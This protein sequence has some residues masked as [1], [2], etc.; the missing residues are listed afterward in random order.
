[1]NWG[2]EWRHAPEA[3]AEDFGRFEKSQLVE[4]CLGGRRL[5]FAR[6]PRPCGRCCTWFWVDGKASIERWYLSP[7]VEKPFNSKVIKSFVP[8]LRS[9]KCFSCFGIP[10]FCVYMLWTFYVR[11]T[12][13][14]HGYVTR[15]VNLHE[16]V[17]VSVGAPFM[18]PCATSE[19]K[20]LYITNFRSTESALKQK[21]T[22]RLQ[23]AGTPENIEAVNVS[24]QQSPRRSLWKQGAAVNLSI[25]SLKRVH[26]QD[27]QIHSYKTILIQERGKRDLENRRILCAEIQ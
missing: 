1:M 2:C 15:L 27:L 18:R 20:A 4:F 13:P 10:M 6:S 7:Y 25:R 26:L 12:Y 3:C 19:Q 21:S 14:Y 16:W 9:R 24:I 17:R 8:E 23:T 5:T 11:F 22:G